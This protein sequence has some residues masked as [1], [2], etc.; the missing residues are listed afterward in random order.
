M[1]IGYTDTFLSRFL[2]DILGG[3]VRLAVQI[4]WSYVFTPDTITPTSCV[5]MQNKKSV[6]V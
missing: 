5:T 6:D 3:K 2:I 1:G 4:G